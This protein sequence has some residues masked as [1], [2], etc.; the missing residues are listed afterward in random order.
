MSD[1]TDA[2]RQQISDIAARHGL[3]QGAVEQMA[4]AVAAGGGTM[5]QFNI[6]ELGGGGQWMAGGMT[7]VGDMFNYGLK[8]TVDSLCADLSNAMAGTAFF[9]APQTIA[10]AAWWPADL[11]QPSAVGGQNQFRYAYFPAAARVAVDP[12]NGAP[13]I[14]L[15]TLDHQIG[16]FSQQ[17]SG[18]GDPFGGI[19]F[20]SQY[21][22]F[23][24]SSLPRAGVPEEPQPASQ[25]VPMPEQPFADAPPPNQAP[26]QEPPRTPQETGDILS[27]IERLA[28]LRDAGALTE[29]E[30]AAK[31]AELLKR[32]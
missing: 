29:E 30:F 13:V 27:T 2:G 21:G 19:S 16:G 9:R 25:P 18:Y 24:L 6:P 4:R 31:K 26:F 11:G 10:G 5:A 20:S 15:D 28:A 8:A 22:Q 17:Q 32:L 7:M 12:G 23:A 14:L 1:L 3:S